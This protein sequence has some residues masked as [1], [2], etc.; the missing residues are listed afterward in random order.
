MRRTR[1]AVAALVVVAGS[2]IGLAPAANALPRKVDVC[3]GPIEELDEHAQPTGYFYIN[4]GGTY[5]RY[6]Y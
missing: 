2:V 6:H 1:I 4:C 3:T 5:I